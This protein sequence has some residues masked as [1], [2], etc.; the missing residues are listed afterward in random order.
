M[1]GAQTYQ[2]M[3]A[4]I[5]RTFAAKCGLWVSEKAKT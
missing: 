4:K 3:G 5:Q 2:Q 1:M